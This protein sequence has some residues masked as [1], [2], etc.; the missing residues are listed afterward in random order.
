MNSTARARR[1]VKVT[2]LLFWCLIMLPFFSPADY[3]FGAAVNMTF[4][5][6][7][8]VDAVYVVYRV[9]WREF[10][11]DGWYVCLFLMYLAG[12][13]PT[14]ALDGAAGYSALAIGT[15]KVLIFA[16]VC[17]VGLKSFKTDFLRAVIIVG[18]ISA[19]VC[20]AT[21]FVYRDAGGMNPL[22]GMLTAWGKHYSD[23]YYYFGHD[24]GSIFTIFPVIVCS[25][26]YDLTYRARVG[27]VTIALWGA[28]T[29]SCLYV[30]SMA[31]AVILI[32]AAILTFLITSPGAIKLHYWAAVAISAAMSLL[33][34]VFRLYDVFEFFIV[35]V[36]GKSMTLTNRTVIWDRSID[37]ISSNPIFGVGTGDDFYLFSVLG[38]N[39][40]HNMFLEIM[41]RSG[42]I[43]FVLF[44]VLL[45]L[46]G[47]KVV[48]A[49]YEPTT[50]ILVASFLCLLVLCV[51]DFYYFNPL[52]WLV[53][54][55][56]ACTNAEPD[57]ETSGLE[58]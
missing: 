57:C 13:A 6:L 54:V 48:A 8:V 4:N 44:L 31:A 42:L 19:L 12:V 17:Q 50:Q 32:A 10:R 38:T 9:V 15:L 33:I 34:A 29:L 5:A 28:T 20:A 21:M 7:L 41:F 49:R 53:P 46:I 36:L 18:G 43:G 11:F 45:Y 14:L 25:A 47:R 27:S 35:G 1:E 22:T 16:L 51:F 3:V 56:L 2:S 24:T 30:G 55:L 23:A 26:Y 52:F 39:H 37:A 58:P 40:S